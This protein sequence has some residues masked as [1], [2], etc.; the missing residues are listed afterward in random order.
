MVGVDSWQ[1]WITETGLTL[2]LAVVAGCQRTPELT[3]VSSKEV[4]DLDEKLQ[5]PI[6]ELLLK[7]C[8]TPAAP[9]FLG[10]DDMPAVH[11]KYGAEVYQRRCAACHGVTGDGKGE[12]AAN[13]YPRPRDYRKGLFKFSSTPFGVKPVREDLVRTVRQGAKGT[14]MPSFNLLTDDD[15]QAV[16]DYVLALSYRGQLEELLMTEAVNEETVEPSNVTGY[17]QEIHEAWKRAEEQVIIPLTRNPPYSKETIE[18]GKKLFLTEEAGCF[19]CHGPD[20]RGQKATDPAGN[21]DVWGFPAPAADLTA[22]MFHGGGRPEDI[23]RRIYGGISG[24]VMP[25]FK[26][27]LSDRPETFWHLVHYVQYVSDARRREVLAGETQ[28]KGV[29]PASQEGGASTDSAKASTAPGST[30]EN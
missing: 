24:S 26:D 25:S 27:K 29:A 5:A 19:K 28:A 18:L 7:Y 14:S 21:K 2:L 13:M 12:V 23:Y 9:K 8:G 16:V 22:G 20:G 3:Y 15:L 1:R 10:H 11:L 6:R 4:L 30:T 17:I